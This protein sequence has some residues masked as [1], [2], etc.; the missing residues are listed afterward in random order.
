MD[1]VCCVGFCFFFG[2]LILALLFL[3]FGRDMVGVGTIARVYAEESVKR[4]KPYWE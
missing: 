4:G 2:F 3:F 1:G